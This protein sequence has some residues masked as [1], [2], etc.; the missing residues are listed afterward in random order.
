[1]SD[2]AGYARELSSNHGDEFTCLH[3]NAVLSTWEVL[4]VGRGYRRTYLR[5]KSSKACPTT[6]LAWEEL[7]PSDAGNEPQYIPSEYITCTV[8]SP[9]MA[10]VHKGFNLFTM[11]FRPLRA[12]FKGLPAY[13]DADRKA[14]IWRDEG[15]WYMGDRNH[16]VR[17]VVK[18]GSISLS[19]AI[20]SAFSEQLIEDVNGDPQL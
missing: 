9:A 12:P 14:V 11:Q 3:F 18:D 10:V 13:G 20:I 17:Y 1:M 16:T 5:G 8:Y 6:V 7:V 15:N 19:V 2:S 4:S